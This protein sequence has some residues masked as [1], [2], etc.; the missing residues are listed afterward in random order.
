MKK[1]ILSAVF[2]ALL[3]IWS[4][5]LYAQNRPVLKPGMIFIIKPE[6]HILFDAQFLGRYEFAD[7]FSFEYGGGFGINTTTFAYDF[8]LGGVLTFRRGKFV[9]TIRAAFVLKGL[10]QFSQSPPPGRS[11]GEYNNDMILAGSFGPEFNW[12][13]KNKRWLGFGVSLELGETVTDFEG[14]GKVFY[15]GILPYLNF[16]F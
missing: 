8:V 4:T 3:T 10:N 7:P 12:I 6:L 2:L 1:V 13:M 5:S 14:K 15:L 16:V 11:G 9:P